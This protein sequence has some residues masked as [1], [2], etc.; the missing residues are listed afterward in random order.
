VSPHVIDVQHAK[1]G[2]L[3][4]PS[5]EVIEF[6]GLPGFPQARRFACVDHGSSGPVAWLVSL[7]ELDLALPVSDLRNLRADVAEVLSTEEL[8][9]VGA[10]DPEEVEVLA[11]VNMRHSP[12]KVLLEAPL[13]IHRDSRRGVQLVRDEPVP[14]R[15]AGDDADALGPFPQIESKPQT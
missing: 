4:V 12:P 15:P 13:I 1:L 14:L 7:D 5:A 3:A 10:R 2:S 6:D 9:R 8:A 11:I